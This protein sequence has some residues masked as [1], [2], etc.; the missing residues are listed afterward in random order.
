[1][2]DNEFIKFMLL[3][4]IILTIHHNLKKVFKKL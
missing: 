3:F 1:M 4:S 2:S